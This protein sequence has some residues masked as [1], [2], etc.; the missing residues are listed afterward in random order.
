MMSCTRMANDFVGM[1]HPGIIDFI[2]QL[3]RD[4]D[5][6]DPFKPPYAKLGGLRG[7]FFCTSMLKIV[8]KQA[9]AIQALARGV[10]TRRKIHFA[11]LSADADALRRIM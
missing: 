1:D 11:L 7:A 4:V 5:V 3:K 6:V 2:D 8:N 9:T 10:L